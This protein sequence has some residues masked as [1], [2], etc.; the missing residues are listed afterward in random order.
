MGSDRVR[1]RGL[2][3]ELPTIAVALVIY[4]GWI[5]T[6]LFWRVLPWPLLALSGGW[7]V[8]W[9]SSLQ[10]EVIHGHPSRSRRVN[11]ALGW[12]PLSLWLPYLIYRRSHLRHHNDALL[13]DPIEDPESA[14]LT[15][16]RYERIGPVGRLIVRFDTTLLGRLLIGPA[17]MIGSFLVSEALA[18]GRG[19]RS[20][21][22]IWAWHLIGVVAVLAWT[23]LVCGMPISIYL[24]AFVYPGAAFARLRSYAEHRWS[25][26]P[27]ERTAIVEDGGPFALLFL[28]NNLHVLH[29]DRPTV[30]WYALPALYRRERDALVEQNGGLVYRGYADVAQRFLLKPHDRPVHPAGASHASRG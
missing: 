8:A 30:P 14:Y 12:P 16:Q 28:N 19:N 29:H 9:Q 20:H 7:F 24:L 13:T 21:L 1:R 3:L 23:G 4:G 11:D 26:A 2:R 17:I 15:R 27:A 25:P 22:R 5:A 10:H 18:L 6:T